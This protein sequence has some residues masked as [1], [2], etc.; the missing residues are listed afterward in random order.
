MVTFEQWQ[1]IKKIRETKNNGEEEVESSKPTYQWHEED[2]ASLRKT[3]KKHQSRRA[4][5]K[6]KR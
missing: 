5:E 2:N 3:M 1:K 4:R 6:I